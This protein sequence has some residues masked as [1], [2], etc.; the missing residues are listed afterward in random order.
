MPPG[1]AERSVRANVFGSLTLIA[2]PSIQP[3]RGD[4]ESS[5]HLCYL[6]SDVFRRAIVRGMRESMSL[7]PT[8]GFFS[9]LSARYSLYTQ[10]NWNIGLTLLLPRSVMLL[11]GH[12]TT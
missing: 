4:S 12:D 1:F 2:Q 8:G 5:H 9:A 6:V 7:V 10:T 11:A 3:A